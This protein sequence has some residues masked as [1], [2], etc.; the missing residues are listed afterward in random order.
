MIKQAECMCVQE[1]G[2]PCSSCSPGF[3]AEQALGRALAISAPDK[4]LPCK[5][6]HTECPSGTCGEEKKAAV[7][8]SAVREALPAFL[9]PKNH[10]FL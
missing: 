5:Y 10:E 6:P 1:H 7:F 3:R 4:H 8:L 2:G 9:V